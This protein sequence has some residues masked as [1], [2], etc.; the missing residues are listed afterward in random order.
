MKKYLLLPALA[1]LAVS[2]ALAQTTNDSPYPNKNTPGTGTEQ[3]EDNVIEGAKESSEP[4]TVQGAQAGEPEKPGLTGPGTG[5]E[6]R[7]DKVVEGA[8]ESS[9]EGRAS[10]TGSDSMDGEKEKPGISAPGTGS[11]QRDEKRLPQ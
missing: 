7:E 10:T 6:D 9:E 5:T 1:A 2:P 4:G 3:R 8:K 11:E